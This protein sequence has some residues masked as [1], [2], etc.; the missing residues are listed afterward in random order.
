M[1][2]A[3]PLRE[4]REA[5]L[6]DMTEEEL[7]TYIRTRERTLAELREKGGGA[8]ADADTS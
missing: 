7:D 6:R 5:L 8:S 3:N 4:E 1:A 2:D